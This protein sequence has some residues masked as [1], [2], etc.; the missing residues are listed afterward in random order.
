M[1]LLT[2]QWIIWSTAAILTIACYIYI[3]CGKTQWQRFK[4][5]QCLTL[6][7]GGK[8]AFL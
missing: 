7:Q 2:I 5:E 4:M 8:T 3:S 6:Q 1:K